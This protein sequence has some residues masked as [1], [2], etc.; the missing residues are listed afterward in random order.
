MQIWVIYTKKGAVRAPF[1]MSFYV[2]REIHGDF[3]GM[4]VEGVLA[5]DTFSLYAWA[6]YRHGAAH[7]TF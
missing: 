2:G 4:G 6:W 7:V 3:R 1:D 5:N